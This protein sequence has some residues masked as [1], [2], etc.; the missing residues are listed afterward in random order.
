MSSP[1]TDK[2]NAL[3]AYANEITGESD[4]TLSDAVASLASGYGQ[5]GGDTDEGL[6]GVLENTLTE[7]TSDNVT[8][9]VSYALRGRSAL[10]KVHLKNCRQISDNAFNGCSNVVTL[11]LPGLNAN[12][13]SSALC[14]M[15]KLTHADFGPGTTSI[16][17]NCFSGDTMLTTIILRKASVVPLSNV[18]AFNNTP[19]KSGGTGGTIF[20]PSAL[21]NSY[22]AASNWS[23]V[24]G[25]GTITWAAIEG[26]QYET[27]YADGTPIS[28]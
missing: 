9:I 20:V 10:T 2:I 19:F 12:M 13:G 8:K 26:S 14:Q 24:N 11:V 21:I 4:T 28:A 16:T 3:T 23:T 27:A 25:Y 18:N 7:L 5:G 22:K 1:L 6:V 15:V 17:A